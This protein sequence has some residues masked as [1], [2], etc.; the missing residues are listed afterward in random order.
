[1]SE[2]QLGQIFQLGRH[3]LYCGDALSVDRP[4]WQA[5]LILTDPPFDME[6]R[7]VFQAITAFSDRY[8]VAGCGNHYMNLCR[9]LDFHFEVISQ[10]SKPQS[11][12]DTKK[13]QI[14]HWN[15]AFLTQPGIEHCFD[16]GLAGGYFPSLIPAYKL[17]IQGNYAKPLQWAID[18][19]SVCH[20][21][22][23]ADPFA[24]AGTVLIAAEKLGKTCYAI[25]INPKLCELIIQ[26]WEYATKQKARVQRN[27]G[28]PIR[29]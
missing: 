15:N 20:A 11:I 19:L 29:R 14:L 4:D 2:V 12:P 16:R 22:T 8:I 23:I 17:D 24:G 3:S 26:R 9:K 13:P 6:A 7:S 21:Q 5:D 28:F 1:M 10:R 18:L 25:E 27:H